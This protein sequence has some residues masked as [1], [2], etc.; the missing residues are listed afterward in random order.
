MVEPDN[1]AADNKSYKKLWKKRVEELEKKHML[2]P[3]QKE[4]M[5]SMIDSPDGEN[6]TLAREIVKVKLSEKLC[7][8]LNE[9]QKS[10]FQEI[11]DF[12]HNPIQDAVVL[13]GYAGTGKT[14]LVKR[15][16]EYIIQTHPKHQ[17]A[18]TAPTNKAVQVLYRNA[19]K[20]AYLFEDIFR[21]NTRLVYSTIHKLLG[22]KEVITDSG[23]QV[24]RVDSNSKTGITDYKYLIVDEVSMLDDKLYHDIMKFCTQVR[25][26][27][28]GGNC[29]C[30]T[31][32]IAGNS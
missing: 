31:P 16:I 2:D 17:I 6:F 13:K 8:G 9:G 4:A 29:P 23:E 14:F 18:I 30:K 15:I 1:E 24:F 19:P 26:I 25:V 20:N 7:D 11:V 27:F 12:I 21:G 28:M 5:E 10:A 3:S 22:L 32:L